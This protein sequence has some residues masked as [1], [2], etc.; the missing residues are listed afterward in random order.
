MSETLDASTAPAAQPQAVLRALVVADLADSTALVERL[1][2][3]R[4]AELL[5]SHDRLARALIREHGGQEIDKTDGFLLIFERPVQAAAFALHYQ[6]ALRELS[7]RSG[8][9]LRARIGIHVGEVLLWDNPQEDI[10]RGAKRVEVEGLAKPLA[11]RLMGLALP[12]QILLSG[13]AH[14]LARRSCDQLGLSQ[15]NV[16]WQSHGEFRLKG[17]AEPQP[18]FELGETGVAPFTAPP[19]SGKAHRHTPFWRRPLALVVESLALLV[20]LALALWPVLR[21]APA[22]AF[23]ERDWVVIA[24]LQ[25]FTGEPRF[26][27]ALSLATRVI[28]EQSQHVNVLS[29]LRVSDSLQR[30]G[31]SRE[32][33]LDA[34]TAAEV[35]QREGARAVLQPSIRPTPAGFEFVI[36]V[37]DPVSA[38]TVYTEVAS[39]DA[40]ETVLAAV[41]E[42][43][44]RVRG[45]LGEALQKIEQSSA[46]V[47][48]V[49]SS[50]LDALRAYALGTEQYLRGQIDQ[51]ESHFRQAVALDPEFALAIVALARVKLAHNNLEDALTLTRDAHA[52]RDRLTSREALYLD[53]SLAQLEFRKDSASAWDALA[54]LYPD[55]HQALHNASILHYMEGRY[56][57]QAE[58]ATR[59][60]VPQSITRPVSTFMV[61]LARLA[62]GDTS[63]ALRGFDEAADLGFSRFTIEPAGALMAAGRTDDAFKRLHSEPPSNEFRRRKRLL[64]ELAMRVDAGRWSEV[65]ASHAAMRNEINVLRNN[66][67]TASYR[68]LQAFRIAIASTRRETGSTTQRSSELLALLQEALDRHAASPPTSR[69]DTAL[70]AV[71]LGYQLS[72]DQQVEAA[73][74]LLEATREAV[75]AT[76]RSAVADIAALLEA[77]IALAQDEAER[78]FRLLDA[79]C[80]G[81]EVLLVR[82]LRGEA[83]R[84]LGRTAEA[85]ADAEYVAANRGRA[86][87]E[88]A[89]EG[90][91]LVENAVQVNLSHLRAAEL[92]LELDAPERA[93]D[94]LQAFLRRW[95]DHSGLEGLGDWVD[96]IRLRLDSETAP[97]ASLAS[98]PGISDV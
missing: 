59:A 36:D 67:D 21:P 54:E 88:W 3:G 80:T 15:E 38:S 90:V 12:G 86:Y 14:S 25:N 92:A 17:V 16:R 76:P 96:R 62:Q 94:H 20:L 75:A 23:A 57:R 11:A 18:V 47:P 70:V 42:A 93:R 83:A 56:A 43:S 87:A 46:P 9:A 41:G 26:D 28:V 22:I 13:T 19:W 97:A 91:T 69:S 82:V 79:R 7:E 52:L 65:P 72:R 33:P 63:E 60:A 61:A 34:A 45:R 71:Y 44:D 32:A 5:R 77:R 50:D 68:Q 66:P 53:A 49:T 58:F 84:R 40:A 95:P 51:A 30:M 55:F 74:R 35:A 85:L 64:A 6:R 29:P 27:H 81:S 1:G 31:R 78:A 8:H 4:A 10:A 24:D 48:Q 98:G 89:G 73:Q 2:D 37:L 39:A